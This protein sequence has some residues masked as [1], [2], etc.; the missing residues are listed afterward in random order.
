MRNYALRSRTLWSGIMNYIKAS[1]QSAEAL[2]PWAF[3]G[4]QEDLTVLVFST[5]INGFRDQA[6]VFDQLNEL[7]GENSWTIDLDDVDKVLRV[8]G[9]HS[10][11]K[12][13][14]NVFNQH[15]FSCEVMS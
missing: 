15:S 4:G 9:R 7:V 8:V 11:Q 10:I 12:E 2:K 13:I 3:S 6:L 14:I 5:S 1:A